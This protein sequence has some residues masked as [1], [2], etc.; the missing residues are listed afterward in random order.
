[1]T[2][3]VVRSNMD[4]VSLQKYLSSTAPVPSTSATP[5]SRCKKQTGHIKRPMNAFMIFSQHER[6][7]IT[8]DCVH[9]Q[10]VSKTLG[11]RWNALSH[12]DKQPWILESKR[13]GKLH[14]EQYPHYKYRPNRKTGKGPAKPKGNRARKQRNC[15]KAVPNTDLEATVLYAD[16][17]S[18]DL[19]SETP[20]HDD[21]TPSVMSMDITP[22]EFSISDNLTTDDSTNLV[23]LGD[24]TQE[25]LFRGD[26]GIQI[27]DVANLDRIIAG[28]SMIINSN[29]DNNE[30]GS[31]PKSPMI[32]IT[33]EMKAFFKT[34]SETDQEDLRD[35][36]Y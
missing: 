9:H 29:V 35:M 33:D 25:D 18:M 10:D 14:R 16:D 2:D 1:M 5:T 13:L 21:I 24:I 7:K 4:N 20:S 19:P 15:V 17:M 11:K 32:A 23:H 8:K 12:A 30:E 26:C 31:A 27:E 22:L 34:L 36:C 3:L 6:K 28:E